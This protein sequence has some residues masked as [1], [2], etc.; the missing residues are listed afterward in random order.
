MTGTFADPA[1]I[2]TLAIA[3][4]TFCLV[5]VT[6]RQ[7]RLSRAELDLSIRP[8]LA[9][10]PTILDGP[11]DEYIQFGAPG[12]E[13]RRV[14]TGELDYKVTPLS[15]QVSLAFRNIGAGVAVILGAETV[16]K[17]KFGSVYVSRKF[18]PVGE[19]VRVNIS[20]LTDQE[21]LKRFSTQWWAVD[22]FVI[23]ISYSDANGKQSLTSRASL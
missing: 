7:V 8:M 22:G 3:G 5:I 23:A 12:R 21:E 6:Y 9:E 14:R 1:T 16:P 17:L 4:V 20:F 18:L 11:L 10:S 2:A 15:F 13:G 19:T